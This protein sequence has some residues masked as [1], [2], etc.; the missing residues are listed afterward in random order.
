MPMGIPA[1]L[2]LMPVPMPVVAARNCNVVLPAGAAGAPAA[3]FTVNAGPGSAFSTASTAVNKSS[4]AGGV[5]SSDNGRLR[6]LA[7]L[8]GAGN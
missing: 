5:P 8:G 7:A 4:K 3:V 6:G 1:P 2:T